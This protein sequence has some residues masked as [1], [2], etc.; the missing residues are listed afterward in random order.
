MVKFHIFTVDRLFLDLGTVIY[1]NNNKEAF[2][3]K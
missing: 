1:N 3:P 2:N